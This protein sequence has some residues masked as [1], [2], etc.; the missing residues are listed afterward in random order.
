[1][2]SALASRGPDV[3]AAAGASLADAV[4]I[5]VFV[6]DMG[7][8]KEVNEVYATFSRA[9]RRARDGR[10]WRRCGSARTWRW[11][12]SSACPSEVSFSPDPVRRRGETHHHGLRRL[13]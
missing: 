9:I 1:M 2:N 5:G 10:A 6:T 13:G 12:R 7:T 4:R 3:C 8:F 11:T